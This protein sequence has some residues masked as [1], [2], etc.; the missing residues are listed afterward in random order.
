[1]QDL[2]FKQFLLKFKKEYLFNKLRTIEFIFFIA[3]NIVLSVV[4]TTN[5][6]E[7]KAF[8]G[9]LQGFIAVYLAF[10][11]G[12]VGML[13]SIISSVKDIFFITIGYL[14]FRDYSYL[15]GIIFTILTIIWVL[16]VGIISYRQ[17]RYRQE[18]RKLAITDELTKVFNKRFLHSTLDIE[19]ESSRGGNSI[20]LIL[21][22]I[23][24]FRMYND[25]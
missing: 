18:M 25:L 7:T 20:G 13:I 22:D 19:I 3:S 16:I 8:L 10:R 14:H 5:T 4:Q 2:Y 15:V 1:M 21:I 12:V 23:D 6:V 9:Q 24:N 17:E 11:F